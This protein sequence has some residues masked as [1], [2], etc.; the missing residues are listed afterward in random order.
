MK[1]LLIWQARWWPPLEGTLVLRHRVEMTNDVLTERLGLALHGARTFWE[2][3][4]RMVA[5]IPAQTSSALALSRH[6]VESVRHGHS[7]LAS[8]LAPERVTGCGRP[9]SPMTTVPADVKSTS[10][11]VVQ[12]RVLRPAP[13]WH[14]PWDRKAEPPVA[15]RSTF[16]PA[17]PQRHRALG[18]GTM[19]PPCG[20]LSHG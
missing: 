16:L 6:L 5:M 1:V 9:Q 4:A 10:R 14:H 12:V 18:L 19:P 2:L 3:L 8:R 11:T 7:R 13:Q 15:S 17:A 20:A